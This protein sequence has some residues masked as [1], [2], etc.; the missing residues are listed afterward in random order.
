MNYTVKESR[1]GLFTSFDT[2][3]NPM[4][5]AMTEES[6]RFVTENIRIPVLQGTWDAHTS[7]LGDAVVTGK[8]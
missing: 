4:T 2:D 1:F 8:L 3:N 7:V 5:T 6:C